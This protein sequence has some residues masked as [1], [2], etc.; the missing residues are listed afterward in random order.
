MHWGEV[1]I[2]CAVHTSGS[3]P[4]IQIQVTLEAV[5]LEVTSVLG[6]ETL[7]CR[8]CFFFLQGLIHVDTQG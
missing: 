4:Q 3:C 5:S 6:H 2:H 7:I 1:Q 8:H